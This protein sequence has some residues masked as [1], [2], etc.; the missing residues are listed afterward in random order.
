MD[1]T[2]PVGLRCGCMRRS[3][4][5]SVVVSLLLGLISMPRGHDLGSD[6][7][8]IGGGQDSLAAY[9][10]VMSWTRMRACRLGHRL[11]FDLHFKTGYLHPANIASAIAN[12]QSRLHNVLCT[13]VPSVTQTGL[14]AELD[15]W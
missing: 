3:V 10:V 6:S 8:T 4:C 14:P 13:A 1:L 7:H 15:G 2:L 12:I 11:H 5:S 9:R